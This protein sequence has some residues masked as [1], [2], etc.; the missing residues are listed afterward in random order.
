MTAGDGER[1][2]G[3][4][5]SRVEAFAK[6]SLFQLIVVIGCYDNGINMDIGSDVDPRCYDVVTD[7]AK[8]MRVQGTLLELGY[9]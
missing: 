6:P 8:T 3:K 7:P 9:S 2:I 4:R 1:W 5:E